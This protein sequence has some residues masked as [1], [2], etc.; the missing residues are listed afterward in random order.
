ML[1]KIFYQT[2]TTMAN[3][4]YYD[5]SK[6][7]LHFLIEKAIQIQSYMGEISLSSQRDI[8]DLIKWWTT[9]NKTLP[10]STFFKKHN[11]PQAF[12]SGLLN[13]LMFNQQR[14]ISDVQASHLENIV[15]IFT[16]LVEAVKVEGKINLQKSA[17]SD[18][19]LFVENIITFK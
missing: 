15:S 18:T 17:N 19:I 5:I 10:F 11:S 1:R 3:T 7:D 13:N 9:S 12:V 14:D 8:K 4:T 6:E 2:K 16:Q